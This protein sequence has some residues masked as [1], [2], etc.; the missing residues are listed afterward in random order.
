MKTVR[1]LLLTATLLLVP[2]GVASAVD[3]TTSE[4]IPASACEPVSNSAKLQLTGGAWEFAEGQ[5]GSVTLRCPVRSS[6]F[7]IDGAQA[8]RTIRIVALV[9]YFSDPDGDGGTYGL[10]LRLRKADKDD[11]SA[12]AVGDHTFAPSQPAGEEY[13]WDCVYAGLCIGH[14]MLDAQYH[15]DVVLSRSSLAAN[16]HFSATGLTLQAPG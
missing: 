7:F 4:T 5:T 9:A 8:T 6:L 15:I 1:P 16:P 3:L 10:T 12:S 14:H 13:E 2:S 11:P